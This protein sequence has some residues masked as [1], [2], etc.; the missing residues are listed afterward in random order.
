MFRLKKK[1]KKIDKFDNMDSFSYKNGIDKLHDKIFEEFEPLS[2][3]KI[4]KNNVLKHFTFQNEMPSATRIRGVHDGIGIHL[5]FL[6][7][8]FQPDP[9]QHAHHIL[10][11]VQEELSRPQSSLFDHGSIPSQF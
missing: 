11:D 9:Q 7:T 6:E 8:R 4:V 10:G 3:T 5:F 1:P 2:I